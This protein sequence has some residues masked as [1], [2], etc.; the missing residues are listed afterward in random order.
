M[1]NSLLDR[2]T[3]PAEA[4]QGQAKGEACKALTLGV[5]CK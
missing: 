3:Y 1:A 2:E 5:K 4:D